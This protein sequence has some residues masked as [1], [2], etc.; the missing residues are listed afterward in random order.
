MSDDVIGAYKGK[1]TEYLRMERTVVGNE[2]ILHS[3]PINKE[4]YNKLLKPND[5]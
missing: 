5:Q 1:E 3:H 2:E 4:Q